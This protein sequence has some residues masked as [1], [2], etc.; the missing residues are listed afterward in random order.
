MKIC[1]YNLLVKKYPND[2]ELGE[3]VRE[4]FHNLDESLDEKQFEGKK[5]YESPDGKVV[6]E[7]DFLQ[8]KRKKIT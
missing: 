5:I 2:F 4:F 6:Y 8:Q 7:R 1:F 3:K